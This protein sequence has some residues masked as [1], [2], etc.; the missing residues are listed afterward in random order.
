[1]SDI[2]YVPWLLVADN[3][4]SLHQFVYGVNGPLPHRREL[5]HEYIKPT[6]EEVARWIRLKCTNGIWYWWDKT[7]LAGKAEQ[8]L[9]SLEKVFGDWGPGAFED[10]K[11][12][13]ETNARIQRVRELIAEA[14]EVLG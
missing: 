5:G 12:G 2:R 1:M 6:G 14:T 8:S 3:L 10:T 9:R 13:P 7:T 11:A 4:E